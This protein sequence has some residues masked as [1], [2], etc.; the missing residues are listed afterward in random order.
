MEKTA[1]IIH[2]DLHYAGA[3]SMTEV[4]GPR[5]TLKP[6]NFLNHSAVIY[7]VEEPSSEAEA[8][9]RVA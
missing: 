2:M 3:I 9:L 6:S 7:R 1:P 5:L 8:E 4:G